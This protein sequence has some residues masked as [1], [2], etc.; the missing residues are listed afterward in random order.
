VAPRAPKP[1]AIAAKS[2]SGT[3]DRIGEPGAG[4]HAHQ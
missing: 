4:M 2:V 1:R 3:S